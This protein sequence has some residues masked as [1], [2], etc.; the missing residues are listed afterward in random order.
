VHTNEPVAVLRGVGGQGNHWLGV[1]LIG[2]DHADVVGATATLTAGDRRLTRFAKGGGSY[3]RSGGRRLRFR[4]GK[5]TPG[6]LPA[7]GPDGT[8]QRFADLKADRYYRITQGDP[9]AE[10]EG[11]K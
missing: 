6:R 1:K 9:K 2:K 4:L 3:A 7:K 8:E 11:S 5:G 10:P